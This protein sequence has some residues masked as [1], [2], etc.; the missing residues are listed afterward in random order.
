MAGLALWFKGPSGCLVIRLQREREWTRVV[1]EVTGSK[2]R[3][4][5]L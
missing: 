5:I 4:E 1:V 2:R 3:L